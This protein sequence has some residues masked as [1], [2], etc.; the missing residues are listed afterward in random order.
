MSIL[1]AIFVALILS[2]TATLA[3][4]TESCDKLI[5]FDSEVMTKDVA[6]RYSALNLVNESN[7]EDIKKK[8]K[9]TVPGYFDGSY[10]EFRTKR[11]EF[12]F[13]F[14][15]TSSLDIAESY[16]KH[17]LSPAGAQAYSECI[18][19]LSSKPIAAWVS[20][21]SVTSKIAVTVKSNGKGSSVISYTVDGATPINEPKSLSAGSSQTLLFEK[22]PSEAFLIVI[23]STDPTN[24]SDD[25]TF[26]ELPAQKRFEIRETVKSYTET[27]M[28]GAGCQGN[29]AGCLI[30][31][32]LKFVAES[33]F[34]I[35]P[36]TVKEVSRQ[37][38]GG[39]G[40]R[41]FAVNWIESRKDDGSI[42][43]LEGQPHSCDGNSGH[44]QGILEVTYKV[45]ATKPYLFDVS[46]K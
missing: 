26:V 46:A 31:R 6:A 4:G 37:T 18:A 30:T 20:N 14:S 3:Q 32:N 9:A 15:T 34:S 25:T 42:Q 17:A 5:Q 16:Y 13:L 7:Y 10:D 19:Q 2:P 24:G 33:G 27:L 29:S 1:R 39:P 23:N 8:A 40:L 21:K 43:T 12:S 41:S 35:N 11:R 28:C 22:K 45:N 36:T 38:V 44:T